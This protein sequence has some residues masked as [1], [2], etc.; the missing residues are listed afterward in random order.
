MPRFKAFLLALLQFIVFDLLWLGSVMKDFNMRQLAD[1]GRFEN[2][3]FQMNYAA[4]A[5][6][7]VL[8]ALSIPFYVL[9]LLKPK[10]SPLKIFFSGALLGLIVYG[11]FDMTNLAILR[12]Y[13]LAFI[14]PDMAWGA[15]VF[16]LVALI[17]SKF[18]R[19]HPREQS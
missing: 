18:E 1:I 14:A 11:V 6:T 12:N 10:D 13:P 15:F 9:P 3:I 4:A 17:T 7:Y 5:V 8:M 19:T 2:G 16:G